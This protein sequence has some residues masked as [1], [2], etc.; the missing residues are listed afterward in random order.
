[1]NLVNI[2]LLRAVE[3]AAIEEQVAVAANDGEQVIE[4]VGNAAGKAS[5]CFH[6]VSLAKPL[7]QLFLF[8]LSSTQIVAH[9]I[10]GD[11]YF[12][13]LILAGG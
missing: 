2:A 3:R 9:A 7:F 12:P 5:N 11:R 1:M 13:D 6:L 8:G 4:I 10:E